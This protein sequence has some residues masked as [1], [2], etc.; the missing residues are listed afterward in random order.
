MT[1]CMLDDILVVTLD[2]IPGHLIEH[3]LSYVQGLSQTE[4]SREAAEW[5]PLPRSRGRARLRGKGGRLAMRARRGVAPGAYGGLASRSIW[6]S[7]SRIVRWAGC[8]WS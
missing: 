4:L 8:S 5:V 7:M 3:V 2:T 1:T 6:T